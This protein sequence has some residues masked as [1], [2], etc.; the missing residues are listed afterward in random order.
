[1]E[2]Y[3]ICAN[4]KRE[5]SL[6]NFTKDRSRK[7]GLNRKC[8]EC[9]KDEVGAR[10]LAAGKKC[11]CGKDIWYKSEMCMSCRKRQPPQR[12]HNAH[13]YAFWTNYYEHPNA[14]R[15]GQILEHVLVMSQ[16]LGRPLEP[17]ENV[18][19]KNGVRDDNRIENL[20]LWS[21]SQPPGQRVQDKVEW[22]IELLKLYAPDQLIPL[23]NN[24]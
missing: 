4:C 20:E 11:L 1:M 15:Q 14:F 16:H 5:R 6:D 18:H 7:D 9:V 2:D 23:E 8:R 12:R 24:G 22:A 3:K 13:G 17:H 10:N 19:H 21:T